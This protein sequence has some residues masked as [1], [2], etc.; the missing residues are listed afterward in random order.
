MVLEED[1]LSLYIPRGPLVVKDL[2]KEYSLYHNACLVHVSCSIP[3]FKKIYFKFIYSHVH[4][5]L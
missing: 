4:I 3:V 2:K 5:F 1:R